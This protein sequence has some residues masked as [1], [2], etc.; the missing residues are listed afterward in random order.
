[1]ASGACLC[2]S[3]FRAGTGLYWLDHRAGDLVVRSREGT[4]GLVA[5]NFD[6]DPHTD[7]MVVNTGTNSFS[8]LRGNGEGGFANPVRAQTYT[9]GLRPTV[10]VASRF[11]DDLYL[12]LAVLNEGTADVSI[13]LGDGAGSFVK[14]SPAR[15]SGK[16]GRMGCSPPAPSA[17]PTSI[18]TGSPIFWLPIAGPI[19]CWSTSAF[20]TAS[21]A[22]FT[23]SLPAPT[24]PALP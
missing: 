14:R 24:R 21:S 16:T 11:N 23:A 1:E 6:A 9:T 10:V 7:L 3:R 8:L 22:R 5:G 12:D 15:A 19:T 13:Y 4:A 20:A 2:E 17:S 18:A